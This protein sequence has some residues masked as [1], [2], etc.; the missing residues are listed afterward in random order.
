VFLS[1]VIPPF[2]LLDTPEMKFVD[3]RNVNPVGP[4]QQSV[5]VSILAQMEVIP[6]R[7]EYNGSAYI[8]SVIAVLSLWITSL[9]VPSFAG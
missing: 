5:V 1:H 4:I 3:I 2:T 9:G 7:M 8:V 6:Y